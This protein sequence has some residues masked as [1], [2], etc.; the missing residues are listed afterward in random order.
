MSLDPRKMRELVLLLLYSVD[1]GSAAISDDLVSLISRECKVSQSHVRQAA[2]KAEKVVHEIKACD[3]ILAATCK[4]YRIERIGSVERSIA[5]L[6]IY[7]LLIEKKLPHKVAF[8]EAKR[9]AKKFASEEAAT[10]IHA[11]LVAI[12]E[13]SGLSLNE[14]MVV[15]LKEAYKQLSVD[16]E[17]KEGESPLPS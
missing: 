8:A 4:E 13:Q 15:P 11:L 3:E 5:R 1:V 10:F 16:Q 14:Q 6:G 2:E 7:D 9:L 12:C 17:K